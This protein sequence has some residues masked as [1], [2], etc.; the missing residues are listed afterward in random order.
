MINGK[1]GGSHQAP[2]HSTEG[3]TSTEPGSH[4]GPDVRWRQPQSHVP[5]TDQCPRR[6]LGGEGGWEAGCWWALAGKTGAGHKS[7]LSA[8]SGLHARPEQE[9][10]LPVGWGQVHRSL[11]A[12]YLVILKT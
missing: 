5:R 8:P 2:E 10:T 9:E 4:P 12:I 1:V 6:R 7:V 3:K 11:S